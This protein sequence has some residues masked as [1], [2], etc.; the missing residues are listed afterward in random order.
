M[1]SAFNTLLENTL[2]RFQRGGFLVGDYVKFCSGYS[3]K[4]SFKD[5]TT[6]IQD[7]VKE[8]EK[9]SENMNLRIINIKN[10]YPSS[11]PG[12]ENNTN[13]CVSVDIG[14]DYG[15]GR[16]H[17]ALT[18]PAD[19]LERIDYGINYAPL[20]DAIRRDNMVTLKPEPLKSVSE[21]EEMIIQ[22][23]KTQ[24]GGK[25]AKSDTTLSNK[26]VKIPSETA[27]YV[28]YFKN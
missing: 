28:K 5:L 12:N 13:G 18:V 23:R 2:S 22:T 4:D 19:I 17:C 24:Q 8:V 25:L 26:N 1:N 21:D 16:Y 7:A 6:S 9:M 15:G 27:K 10:K 14:L 3:T 11:Q 20:P